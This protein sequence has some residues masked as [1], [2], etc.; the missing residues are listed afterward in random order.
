MT[1]RPPEA[2]DATQEILIGIV[3]RLDSYLG[4]AAF[5]TWVHRVAVNHLLDRRR[6]NAKIVGLTFDAYA[7]DLIEAL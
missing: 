2:E 1:A 3:T 7:A 6:T 5:M 4:E